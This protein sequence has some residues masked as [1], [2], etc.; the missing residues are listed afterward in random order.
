MTYQNGNVYKTIVI[1]NL[2]WMAEN[3]KAGQYRNGDLIQNLI[4]NSEW[5]ELTFGAWSYFS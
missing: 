5:A 1:G 3:L 4:D 2:E